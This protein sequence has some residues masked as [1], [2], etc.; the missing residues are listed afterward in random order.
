MNGWTRAPRRGTHAKKPPSPADQRPVQ[1]QAQLSG[2]IPSP[3]IQTQ[4]PLRSGCATAN[5]NNG[6]GNDS[7]HWELISKQLREYEEALYIYLFYI[8]F[9]IFF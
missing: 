1:A 3:G 9:L 4:R 5:E 8:E 6:D 7:L 2:Q